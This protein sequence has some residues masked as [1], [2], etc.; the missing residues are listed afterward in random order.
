ME[1]LPNPVDVDSIREKSKPS[2]CYDNSGVKYVASGRLTYQKGFDLLLSWFSEL[3]NPKSTLVILGEGDY[4]SALI[5]QSRL[6]NIQNQV[7]FIGFCD[8]PWQWYSGADVTLVSSRWEGMP[9]VVLESLACGTPVISTIESG[10]ILELVDKVK[11]NGLIAVNSKSSF[12]NE[13]LKIKPT[14]S[15]VPK[16]SLLPEMYNVKSC[17]SKF[18]KLIIL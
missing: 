11:N 4:K 12:I 13:M 2:K 1:L 8:N 18:E 10:G 14:R 15:K 6:L 17:V 7:K 5:E 3:N 16:I 9:N